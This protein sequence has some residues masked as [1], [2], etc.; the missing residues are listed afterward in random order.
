[1]QH[2]TLHPDGKSIIIPRAIA[3]WES[4]AVVPFNGRPSGNTI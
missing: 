1:M 4:M 3:V 2:S